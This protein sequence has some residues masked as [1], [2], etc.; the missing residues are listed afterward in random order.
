MP[1]TESL[2]LAAVRDRLL[3]LP[4]PFRKDAVQ[5]VVRQLRPSMEELKPYLHFSD[6]SYTRTLFYGGPRFEVLV[7]C[8][9]PGQ[10]SPIHDHAA[11]ICSMAVVQGTCTSE[12]YRPAGDVRPDHLAAGGEITLEA[13]GIETFNRDE[14][15]TVIG[16]DIHRVGNRPEADDD[17]VTVHFYLPAIRSMRCFD[18]H[19]GQCTVVEPTTLQPSF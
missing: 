17:L 10:V 8:W 11:S 14:V 16:G 19:T 4:H 5:E 1:L 9:L 2:S 18:E 12:A 6:A 13:T 15:V 7:L 3:E